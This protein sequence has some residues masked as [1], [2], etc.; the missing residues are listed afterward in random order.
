MSTI[1]NKVSEMSDFQYE[2]QNGHSVVKTEYINL[3]S[4]E[5]SGSYQLDYKNM[6]IFFDMIDKSEKTLTFLERRFDYS[7]ITIDYDLKEEGKTPKSLYTIDFI[8]KFLLDIYPLLYKGQKLDDKSFTCFVLTKDPYI[9]IEKEIS[10]VK[11]GFHLQFPLL[12][13]E[14]KYRVQLIK[15]IQTLYPL[16][17]NGSNNNWLLYKCAKSSKKQPYVLSNA[18]MFKNKKLEEISIDKFIKENYDTT[19]LVKILSVNNNSDNV[20]T[21][22]YN[23]LKT[24]SDVIIKTNMIKEKKEIKYTKEEENKILKTIKKYLKENEC[25]H[26]FGFGKINDCFLTLNRLKRGKCCLSEKIHTN[27][28]SYVLVNKDGSMFFGCHNKQ[29]NNGKLECIKKKK[30]VKIIKSKYKISKED[31]EYLEI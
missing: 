13:S 11:H 20:V 23:A 12:S 19:N 28:P 24:E 18:F 30:T 22:K 31:R 14:K 27:R 26:H 21:Y 15:D 25:D 2:N 7:M 29:C 3:Y 9:S 5:P 16:V 10:F 4:M 1:Y 6:D 17:D 8:K